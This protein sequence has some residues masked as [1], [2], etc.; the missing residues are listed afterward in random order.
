MSL[1][2]KCAFLW[3]GGV[4]DLEERNGQ[5]KC[6]TTIKTGTNHAIESPTILGDNTVPKGK[7]GAV[8]F[9]VCMCDT[10]WW[11]VRKGH[12]STGRLNGR[13]LIYGF[14]ENV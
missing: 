9:M 13:I 12:L 10:E 1:G 14:S 6:K 5:G 4:K 2:Q 7:G 8:T 11:C 3:G